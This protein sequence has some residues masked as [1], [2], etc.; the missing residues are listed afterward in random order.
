MK[1]DPKDRKPLVK[2]RKP[3]PRESKGKSR[4]QSDFE[5]RCAAHGMNPTTVRRRMAPKHQRGQDMTLEEALTTPVKTRQQC[6]KDRREKSSWKDTWKEAYGED[7][8]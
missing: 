8:S 6:G 2:A 5:K 3:K 7:P 1:I 4:E